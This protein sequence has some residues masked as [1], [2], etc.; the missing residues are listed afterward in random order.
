M[1]PKKAKKSKPCS[2]ESMVFYT[3]FI[4]IVSEAT[5]SAKTEWVTRLLKHKDNMM[6][7]VPKKVLFCYK[8]WQPSYIEMLKVMPDITFH[9]GMSND[10][11]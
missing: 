5:M 4:M 1:P 11:V 9:Q 3:L 8:Y 10:L 7:P 2:S 6:S